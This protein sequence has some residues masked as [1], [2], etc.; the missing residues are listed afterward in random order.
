MNKTAIYMS[1]LLLAIAITIAGLVVYAG[2]VILDDATTR[3]QAAAD[4]EQQM[5]RAAF[6]DRLGSLSRETEAA[7]KELDTLTRIDIVSMVDIIERVGEGAGVKIAVSSA[8]SGGP[9]VDLPGGAAVQPIQ[10]VVEASGS[11]KDVMH[12]VALFEQLPL[13]SAI[14][15]VSL[16]RG[17]TSETGASATWFLTTRIRV[18]TTA[19]IST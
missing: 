16:Q 14:D 17:P 8:M 4:A 18:F 10:F 15:E 5:A 11:Y 19:S 1:W 6:N 3:S 9:A 12:V 2:T 13:A 7:R